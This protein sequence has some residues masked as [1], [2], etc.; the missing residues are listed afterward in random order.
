MRLIRAG[1]RNT[2]LLN[3]SPLPDSDVIGR[4]IHG[5]FFLS[6][7]PSTLSKMGRGVCFVSVVFLPLTLTTSKARGKQS[8][9]VHAAHCVVPYQLQR[10]SFL[11]RFRPHVHLINSYFR[12]HGA[13]L[14]NAPDTTASST[15]QLQFSIQSAFLQLSRHE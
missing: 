3:N 14:L 4:R 9:H 1:Q 6:P 13:Y 12:P 5:P 10:G 2:A 7:S 15:L 8:L 11:Q